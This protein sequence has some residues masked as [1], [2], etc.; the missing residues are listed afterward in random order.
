MIK[1]LVLITLLSFSSCSPF[2]GESLVETIG[3]SIGRLFEGKS[4]ADVVSGSTQIV[5]TNPAVPAQ[6]YQVSVSVGGQLT[7]EVYETNDGYK[8]YTSV[9]GTSSE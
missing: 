3:T 2:G 1:F 4:T 6:N 9:Q 5:N 8:V 7:Q